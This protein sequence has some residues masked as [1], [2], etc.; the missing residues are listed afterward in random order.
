MGYTGRMMEPSGSPGPAARAQALSSVDARTRREVALFGG[1]LALGLLV[2]PLLIWI[3]GHRTLGPYTRGD[4]PHGLG[5]LSLYGDYFSGL[6]H[7]WLG[8]WVVALGPVVLLLVARLWLALLRR[9]P[10]D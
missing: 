8:Y 4:D 6:A 2:I 10:R 3:I 7:G 1:A 9:L 5:P